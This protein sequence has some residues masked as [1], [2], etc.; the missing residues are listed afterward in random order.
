MKPYF[1]FKISVAKD[2]NFTEIVL[3]PQLF[4]ES[5][6]LSQCSQL[7]LP[8]G[9]AVLQ[10]FHVP[11][12]R[13]SRAASEAVVDLPNSGVVVGF[14]SGRHIV[15]F[16]RFFTGIG[17]TAVALVFLQSISAQEDNIKSLKL[18]SEGEQQYL[19]PLEF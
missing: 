6:I 5:N 1:Y 11:I 3:T 16:H 4:T 7:S 18:N 10:F 15:V 9:V 17:K 14:S 13:I 2:L 12:I 19:R 8:S